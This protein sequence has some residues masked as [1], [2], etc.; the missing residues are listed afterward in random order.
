M[1]K[2]LAKPRTPRELRPMWQVRKA[3]TFSAPMAQNAWD[4]GNDQWLSLLLF[5]QIFSSSGPTRESQICSPK[6]SPGRPPS[7]QLPPASPGYHQPPSWL[8]A[9]PALPAELLPFPGLPL[10]IC[11]KQ[12]S[13]VRVNYCQRKL[14][15]NSFRLFSFALGSYPQKQAHF[16][17]QSLIR[18]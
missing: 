14:G 15:I 4:L 10:H 11:R 8:P 12:G 9:S 3:N 16:I 6:Q 1:P 5:P 18:N 17:K 7:S 13:L 2:T